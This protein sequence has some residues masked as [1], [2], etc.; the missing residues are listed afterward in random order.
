MTTIRAYY[1]GKVIVPDEAVEL[2][3]NQ[4]LQF[5]IVEAASENKDRDTDLL[6]EAEVNTRKEALQRFL[7]RSIRVPDVPLEALRRE[8]LYEDR[9]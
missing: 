6:S 7:A 2:P 8:N 4:P 3:I 1:D 9:L 5:Q